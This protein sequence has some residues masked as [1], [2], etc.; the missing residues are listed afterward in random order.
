MLS[1]TDKVNSVASS[2]FIQELYALRNLIM[3]IAAILII[4]SLA[5]L[6]FMNELF[7]LAINPLLQAL[8]VSTQLLAVE[9]ISPVLS[10]LRVVLFCAF[11][12]SLPLILYVVWRYLAK[13]LYKNEQRTIFP[14]II[15]SFS[16]FFAGVGYCYFVVF[17]FLFQFIAGFAPQAISFAPDIDSYISFVLHMFLAFGLAFEL[18]IAVVLLCSCNIVSLVALKKFRR[19]LIVLSF[20]VAAVITPPD[21]A[22]QLLLAVPL[23]LLYEL[24]LIICALLS[25]PARSAQ[26]MPV[27]EQKQ[28]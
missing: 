25:K 2:K 10:P 5:L 15:S 1:K 6:P 12:L 22:S 13:A 11:C 19:Y 18:P 4:S 3:K 8:P 16:M 26:S 14:F 27:V 7:A 23:V 9:V 17:G 21:V 24:G 20:A 28:G